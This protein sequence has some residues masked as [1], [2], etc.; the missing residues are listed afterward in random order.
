M[1]MLC[2][3][4]TSYHVAADPVS[5][6]TVRFSDVAYYPEHNTAAEV[7]ARHD[8]EISAEI[9]AVVVDVNHDTGD[10]VSA[11]DIVITLDCRSFELQLQQA[12]AA[13]DAVIAQLENARKLL[14]SARLLH[15]QN[16]ISQE[17]YNQRI[18]D[19]ARLQADSLNTKAGIENAKIAVEKCAIR[20]PYDGYISVRH[21]S[22]G[23]LVQPGIP[24]FQMITS[25]QGEVEAHINSLKYESFLQGNDF[26]FVFSGHRYDLRVD[27]ILPVLDRNFRTHTARLY[28]VGQA[29]PTGSH[30]DLRWRDN[31]L[32]LHS[33]LVVVRN[34]QA[35]ILLVANSDRAKFIPVDG[36]VEGHPVTI[37][38]DADTKIIT[39]GRHGLKDGDAISIVPTL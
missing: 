34:K 16:N 5:V 26:A 12:R 38:L 6:K 36:Y 17:I 15:K 20:A 39:T 22:M 29:A 33:N 2:I 4:I 21:I 27:S 7:I 13:H 14:E 32:A 1:M 9:T 8:S 3:V 37:E 28:F 18:A 25:E 19:A 31:M 24:V 23:E 10:K 35:G 11:D 30:G